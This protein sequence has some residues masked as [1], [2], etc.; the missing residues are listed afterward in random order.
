MSLPFGDLPKAI[1]MQSYDGW[2]LRD[3][4]E[5]CVLRI[6]ILGKTD[7]RA[8]QECESFAVQIIADKEKAEFRL[9]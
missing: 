8:S 1:S 6:I 9:L 5:V 7:R 2:E 3:F 4:Y